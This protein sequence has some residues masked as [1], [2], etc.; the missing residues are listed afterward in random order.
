MASKVFHDIPGDVLAAL[1]DREGEPG[2]MSPRRLLGAS[3]TVSKHQL[4]ELYAGGYVEL[5]QDGRAD[6]TPEFS[7]AARVILN[8]LTNLTFRF[9]GS[10][11]TC[12]ETSVLFPGDPLEGE[13]V[14]LN[15]VGENY[16]LAAPVS[17][18][19]VIG[20]VGPAI[21]PAGRDAPTFT[22]EG[23]FEG[24]VAAI[25]FG[26]IDLVRLGENHPPFVTAT[27]LSAALQGSWGLTGFRHLTSYVSA[28]GLMPTP[29]PL[30]AVQYALEVLLAAGV[31]VSD[32]GDGFG[33]ADSVAPFATLLP[34][35][36]PGL[37]WQRVSAGAD[38]ALL[39]SHRV[40]VFGDDSLVL[41]FA[42]MPQGRIFI[43]TTTAAA[44]KDLVVSELATVVSRGL[45][46]PPAIDQ[47]ATPPQ[48]DSPTGG[49][50]RSLVPVASVMVLTPMLLRVT[51]ILGA[52]SEWTVFYALV[53]VLV[54]LLAG[55][56]LWRCPR[57]RPAGVWRG[58]SLYFGAAFLAVLA[59]DVMMVMSI[60]ESISEAEFVQWYVQPEALV[61]LGISILANG[62]AWLGGR[63]WPSVIKA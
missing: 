35:T 51:S 5:P 39:T 61:A 14:I 19:D 55:T 62:G 11:S 48:P 33:L 40:F 36:V 27:E 44:L 4:A 10:E 63:R 45:T 13:G 46:S 16:R 6:S 31:V 54:G 49:G 29:P 7:Q 43:S 57:W 52:E 56:F 41:S 22:F 8:P 15:P 3:G 60:G 38:G 32:G 42:P 24:P 30:V 25:L 23:N 28:V 2:E 1:L 17:V 26:L 58:L 21:P 12:A 53:S 59:Y 34:A 18:D 20:L 37:Q 47:P 9:W 50:W